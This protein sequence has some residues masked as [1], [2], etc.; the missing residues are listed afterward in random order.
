MW[1][2]DREN[3]KVRPT[4]VRLGQLKRDIRCLVIDEN[5]EYLYTGTKSGDILKV[6]HVIII[7]TKKFRCICYFFPAH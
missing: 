1:E 2:I 5:D 6:I 7:I 3:R 4:E